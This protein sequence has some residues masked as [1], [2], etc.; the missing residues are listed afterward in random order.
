MNLFFFII[1]FFRSIFSVVSQRHH[2]LIVLLCLERV[3]L[4][5]ILILITKLGSLALI[6]NYLFIVILA[7][8]AIEASLGLR[9]L[10]VISRKRGNDLIS[11]L[12]LRKC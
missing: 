7:F 6:E 9:L 1:M 3:T 8:G 12:T 2:L 4:T 11:S 10:V 5:S